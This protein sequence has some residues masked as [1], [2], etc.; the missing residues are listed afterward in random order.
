MQSSD[1]K[2]SSHNKAIFLKFSAVFLLLHRAEFECMENIYSALSAD[3]FA[4]PA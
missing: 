4:M 3:C 1:K 2:I